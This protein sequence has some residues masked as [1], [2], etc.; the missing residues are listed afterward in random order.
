M[1]IRGINTEIHAGGDLKISAL[2]FFADEDEVDLNSL[3]QRSNGIKNACFLFGSL[4]KA[5]V[6][7]KIGCVLCD[8][9]IINGGNEIAFR[10]QII[11]LNGFRSVDAEPFPAVS[12]VNRYIPASSVA[13]STTK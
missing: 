10:D 4:D 8:N 13:E 5:A 3:L 11:R 12:Q 2:L 1:I 6:C 9:G 7:E